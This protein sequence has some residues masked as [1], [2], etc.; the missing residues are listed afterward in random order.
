MITPTT[1]A[2][3]SVTLGQPFAIDRY[4]IDAGGGAS[5]G[6]QFDILSTIGQHDASDPSTGGQFELA[7]GF[8]FGAAPSPCFADFNNDG[9]LNILDFVAYQGAFSDQDLAADCTGDG[10]LNVLDFIC[11]QGEFAAGCP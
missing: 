6:G 3:A 11:F 7:G 5:S 10:V 2:L 9:I 8:W 4:T 1:I